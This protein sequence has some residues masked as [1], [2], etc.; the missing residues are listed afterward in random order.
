MTTV[1]EKRRLATEIFVTA[2]VVVGALL[3]V[4]ESATVRDAVAGGLRLCAVT[5]LPSVFPFMILSSLFLSYSPWERSRILGICFEKMTA[6]NR[7]GLPA[8]LGGMFCGFPIGARM[9]A[10]LYQN[11]ALT[12]EEAERL[13][14]FSN[15]A[16]PGFLL[17][18]VGIGMRGEIKDG[19]LLLAVTWISALLVAR[20]FAIG[21]RPSHGG[22]FCPKPSFSL[23]RTLENATHSTINVC[24]FLLF[25][26]IISG[27]LVRWISSPWVLSLLLPWMEVS[28]AT[29]YLSGSSL[30]ADISLIL[31]A[32]ACA[33]AGGSVHM[34]TASVIS[35][36]ELGM[37]TYLKMKGVQGILAM[38]LTPVIS[39]FLR[40]C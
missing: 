3:L 9:A 38:L 22:A 7:A 12:R 1:I 37:K 35:D 11:G 27:L 31:T 34:Q 33:F 23:T 6:V 40:I 8:F 36:S 24:G 21:H 39:L 29:S 14:G 15:N 32:F 16:G 5:I 2:G 10:Q 28:T 25:F 30:S 18:A 19:I 13:M 4:G 26:S 17:C 20:L